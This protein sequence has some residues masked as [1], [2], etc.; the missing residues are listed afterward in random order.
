M[1]PARGARADGSRPRITIPAFP[2]F[3]HRASGPT[4]GLLLMPAGTHTIYYT[5]RW[6]HARDRPGAMASN[7]RTTR[8]FWQ[9]L[10]TSRQRRSAR[11]PPGGSKRRRRRSASSRPGDST[12][13]PAASSPSAARRRRRSVSSRPAVSR[14]RWSAQAAPRGS[15]PP[16]PHP[17]PEDGG[18]AP[19]HQPIKPMLAL[20]ASTIRPEHGGVLQCASSIINGH[21]NLQLTGHLSVGVPTAILNCQ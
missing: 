21:G 16:A 9:G 11:S 15:Q 3:P 14:R 8:A 4:S 6:A 13:W 12:R 17:P 18:G 19:A 20:I 1:Q 7:R 5:Q 10:T 2:L